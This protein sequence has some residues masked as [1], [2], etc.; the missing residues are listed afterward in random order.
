MTPRA[1][2]RATVAKS[3]LAPRA[4][5][6][7]DLRSCATETSRPIA[8]PSGATRRLSLASRSK[9][10]LASLA[11]AG[12][13]T[14]RTSGPSD[15]CGVE[16]PT[17]REQPPDGGARYSPRAGRLEIG[18]SLSERQSAAS[19]ESRTEG[20]LDLSQNSLPSRVTLYQ[21]YPRHRCEVFGTRHQRRENRHA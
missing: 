8:S 12:E 7:V 18:R 13:G 9:D 14:P 6:E 5:S 16:N 2:S 10:N 21:P 15:S 1:D 3:A 4:K 17:D 11:I 19:G 20:S